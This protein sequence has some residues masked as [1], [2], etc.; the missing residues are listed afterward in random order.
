MESNNG[1]PPVTAEEAARRVRE[2]A[3]GAVKDVKHAAMQGADDARTK[4]GDMGHTTASRFRE[5]AGQ[6]ESDLPW[7]SGAFTKSA[8]GLDNVTNSLTRGDMS[9]TLNT[10]SDFARKQPA[11]FIGASVALGFALSRVGKTALEG[12]HPKVETKPAP[13]PFDGV[14]KTYGPA[15]GA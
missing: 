10:L 3:N 2:A 5:L 11:I 4:A 9:Q 1:E 12:V 13:Q 8:E 7:L 6:V 15:S 14:D